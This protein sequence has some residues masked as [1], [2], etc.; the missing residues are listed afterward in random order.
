MLDI[1]FFLPSI[2]G[3]TSFW[4]NGEILEG[5]TRDA[6]QAWY[7]EWHL[8]WYVHRDH[9]HEVWKG[10][11]GHNRHNTE[12]ISCETLGLQHARWLPSCK[13]CC[14]DYAKTEQEGGVITQ[15]REPRKDQVSSERQ[16]QHPQQACSFHWPP[17]PN[18][19]PR[20]NCEH[21]CR[22]NRAIICQCRQVSWN[23]QNADGVIWR[24]LANR[25]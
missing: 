6:P 5:I 9:L 7:L 8:V 3:K 22:Q 23:R 21:S 1:D 4:N 12:T 14:Y 17:G 10:T 13:W 18:R 20:W 19:S 24:R 25:L 11:Q 15:G 16:E 2:H